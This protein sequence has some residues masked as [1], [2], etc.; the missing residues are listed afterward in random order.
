MKKRIKCLNGLSF[1]YNTKIRTHVYLKLIEST[2]LWF[3]V[4]GTSISPHYMMV[5]T[6]NI[7]NKI[8]SFEN[9]QSKNSKLSK[10]GKAV[11]MTVKL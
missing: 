7:L 3:A 11:F 1:P 5:C 4:G 6:W 10:V 2:L 9:M 8:N